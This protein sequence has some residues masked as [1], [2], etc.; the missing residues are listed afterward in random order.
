MVRVLQFGS[1]PLF[2]GVLGV[3]ELAYQVRE[4]RARLSS[5]HILVTVSD[6]AYSYQKVSD[7]KE[8]APLVF[9][10][11]FLS[12]SF[13]M[14]EH[15]PSSL[16]LTCLMCIFYLSSHGM[17]QQ[18]RFLDILQALSIWNPV[19]GHFFSHSN[20]RLVTRSKGCQLVYREWSR[21]ENL[22]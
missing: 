20:K 10:L 7:A 1:E 18:V 13:R 17:L 14:A 6:L 11:V 2:D 12:F 3:D 21:K 4:A 9:I 22:P 5:L 19:A 15:I 8:E 16:Q